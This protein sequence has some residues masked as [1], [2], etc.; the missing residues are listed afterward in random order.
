MRMNYKM[1]AVSL[2]FGT[3][4]TGISLRAHSNC[5]HTRKGILGSVVQPHQA[6]PLQTT[7]DTIQT[8]VVSRRHHHPHFNRGRDGGSVLRK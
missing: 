3:S 1:H 5:K 4:P 6:V 7:T 2:A 8:A